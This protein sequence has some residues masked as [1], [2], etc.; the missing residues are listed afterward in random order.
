MPD[1]VK[2]LGL[3]KEK[4][5]IPEN[6]KKLLR[7][8]KSTNVEKNLENRRQNLVSWFEKNRLPVTV[9]Q[10]N[11]V[12]NIFNTVYIRMPYHSDDCESFNELILDKIRQLV[13]DFDKQNK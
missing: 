8:S 6:L 9:E 5:T 7:T 1:E 4:P 10:G 13:I 12:I 3:V 11:S 2:D